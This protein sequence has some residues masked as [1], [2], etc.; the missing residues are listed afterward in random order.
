[1]INEGKYR[2][3][4]FTLEIKSRPIPKS[5]LVIFSGG[6]DVDGSGWESSA[7]DRKRLEDDFKFIWNPFD[8]PS[9]KKGEYMVKFSS[10]EKL[11]KF[12]DWLD[13]QIKD[14]GGLKED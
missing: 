11:K 12:G 2:F 1:M 13:K 8:A 6:M 3:R 7:G 10:D 14:Y 9:N 4:A 5:F